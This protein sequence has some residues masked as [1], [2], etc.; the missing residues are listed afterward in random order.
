MYIYIY[1]YI[2]ATSTIGVFGAMDSEDEELEVDPG[3]P[4]EHGKG[5][6]DPDLAP[7][8]AEWPDMEP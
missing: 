5:M 3:A 2:L 6:D 1:T 4:W 8:L 7:Q